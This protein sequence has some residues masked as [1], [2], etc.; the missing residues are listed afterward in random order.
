MNPLD[1]RTIKRLADIEAATASPV[2]QKELSAACFMNE[3]SAGQY[4]RALIADGKMHIA[5]WRLDGVRHRVAL[6]VWGAGTNARKPK[7]RSNVINERNRIKRIKA[8]PEAYDL[9]LSRHR[10]RYAA[11]KAISRPN[12]WLSALGAMP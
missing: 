1:T 7:P 2:S 12:N 5:A 10:A 11:K 3:V 6:Y 8:D 9:F 4:L